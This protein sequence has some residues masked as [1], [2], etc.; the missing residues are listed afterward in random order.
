MPLVSMRE[1]AY[2]GEVFF[3]A[4]CKAEILL[5]ASQTLH[6]GWHGGKTQERATITGATTPLE[7]LSPRGDELHKTV[8]LNRRVRGV[9]TYPRFSSKY[10]QAKLKALVYTPRKAATKTAFCGYCT[11]EVAAAYH[12]VTLMSEI[13]TLLQ[14]PL[15]GECQRKLF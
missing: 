6:K 2:Y 3:S 10:P 4:T 5:S 7:F 15:E 8:L 13:F 12:K 14:D 1:I 11:Q 9:C